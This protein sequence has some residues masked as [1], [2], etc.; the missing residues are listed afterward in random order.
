MEHPPKKF[1]RLSPGKEVR[2]RYGY[3]VTCR[4]VVKDDAGQVV[5]LRCTYDPD[6]KGGNAPDGRKVQGDHALGGGGG[7]LARR[8]AALLRICST[9]PIRGRTGCRS[10]ISIRTRW[11]C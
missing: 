2:L 5:A 9:A 7:C 6:S 10:P 11:R 4:E 3:F 8:G 1:Y